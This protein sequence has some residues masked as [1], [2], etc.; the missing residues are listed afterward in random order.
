MN[1]HMQGISVQ[2]MPQLHWTMSVQQM[3]K[4]AVY[5]RKHRQKKRYIK[6]IEMSGS[7]HMLLLNLSLQ[8]LGLYPDAFLKT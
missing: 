1:T 4:S 8:N 7:T 5:H 2:H 6:K 3:Y